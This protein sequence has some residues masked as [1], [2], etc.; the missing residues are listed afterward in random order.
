MRIRIALVLSLLS[1]GAALNAQVPV[2]HVTDSA[3][4]VRVHVLHD[5]LPLVSVLVR[6]G[7]ASSSTQSNG[8]ATLRLPGGAHQLIASRLGFTPETVTVVLRASAD[9]TLTIQ[10]DPQAAGLDDIVVTATRSERR[11][12]DT[13]LRVEVL[14][15]EEIE[16]K[17]L[18]TPGDISMMLNETGGLRVQSTSPSLGGASVRVQGLRGRYTLML[19]DGL[20]LYGGQTGALGLLQIPPMDLAQVEIIKG[21]ASA[22]YGSAALGGVV[23]LVTRRPSVEG[24][25]ELLLNQTTRNG[26]DAVL[27]SSGQLD[28]QWGYTLLGSAHRQ[29][30][31]DV[32]ND[33]W[34][35]MPGYERAVLRPRL[36]WSGENGQ[37]ALF[38]VGTTVEDRR[39]GTIGAR[40]APNGAPYAEEL[41][42]RRVDLGSVARVPFGSGILSART[43]VTGQWH[44]HQFGSVR[45][46]DRHETLFGEISLST[47]HGAGTSVFGVAIQHDGYVATD[48][49]RFDYRYT[50]PALFAQFDL[51]ATSRMSLSASGRLDVHSK[52]GASFNPRISALIRS[53]D[54]W[55]TRLSIGTGTFAPTP[56][57]EETEAT[58]LTPLRSLGALTVE[59]ALGASADVGGTIG[60]FE[61]NGT[62]FASR[63][64]DALAVRVPAGDANA[65]ELVNAD[66]PTTTAGADMLL[67]HRR[68]NFATTATYTFIRSREEAPDG[69]TSRTV[70]LTPRHA[71]GVT[72]V[73]E[74]EGQGR[75]GLEFYYT[76][77]Q[78]LEDNPFLSESKRYALFGAIAERRVGRARLFVNLE[79]LG[80]VRLSSYQPFVRP[81]RGEGGRWT[82]DAWAPLDGRVINGGVRL[83]F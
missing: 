7:T 54:G 3:A 49:S 44:D 67:R 50:T 9:T 6:A 22:L 63:I 25:R 68:G 23:D 48:V 13:P 55:T 28:A 32:D 73:W 18:M 14:A 21:V 75:V 40:T 80:D 16:E 65:L 33:G 46:R 30:R 83:E 81:T 35:D 37:S 51:D 17:M 66:E 58:G 4:V 27:W 36:F 2:P 72:A 60:A 70:P 77:A 76:G 47:A 59:R 69:R 12:E 43:S 74:A 11:I 31:T 53:G 20:P 79:N 62:L 42:T 61:M 38:T 15:R 56:L 71:A 1:M 39:G 24:E 10:L 26:T 64:R 57:T 29:Q 52:Y 34:T 45:E 82:T 19:S 41:D 78:A 8:V 5:T